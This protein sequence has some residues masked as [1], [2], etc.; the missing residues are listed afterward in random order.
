MW[1]QL[2]AEGREFYI[3]PNKET[4]FSGNIQLRG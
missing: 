3:E 1:V 2:D 4:V